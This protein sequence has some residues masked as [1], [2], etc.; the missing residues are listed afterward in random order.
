MANDIDKSRT[1]H[2]R[3]QITPAGPILGVSA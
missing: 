2:S 1:V 3:F